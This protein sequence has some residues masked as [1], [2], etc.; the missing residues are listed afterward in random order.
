MGTLEIVGGTVLLLSSVIGLLEPVKWFKSP[1]FG[2]LGV[3][4]QIKESTIIAIGIVLGEMI[5][6]FDPEGNIPIWMFAMSSLAFVFTLTSLVINYRRLKR[7]EQEEMLE[8]LAEKL[9]ESVAK[10]L[11]GVKD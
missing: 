6:F 2:K 3:V 10:G 5:S 9:G 8:K 11:K 1:E 4:D 7:F